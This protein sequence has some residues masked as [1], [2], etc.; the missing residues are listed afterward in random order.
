MSYAE[1]A[2]EYMGVTLRPAQEELLNIVDHA[3]G[4]GSARVAL[5]EAPTGVGK[6]MVPL[7]L[8]HANDDMYFIIV[9]PTTYLQHQYARDMERWFDP[10]DWTV[11]M[12][13][14]NYECPFLREKYPD[15][16]EFTAADCVL[17]NEIGARCPYAY[18]VSQE[19]LYKF[20]VRQ[21]IFSSS[22]AAAVMP[23]Y[24]AYYESLEK[25]CPYYY[26]RLLSA[27]RRIVVTNYDY[28]FLDFFVSETLHFPHVIVF[29]EAHALLDRLQSRFSFKI[30]LNDRAFSEFGVDTMKCFSSVMGGYRDV[31]LGIPCLIRQLE[32][33][34]N[35]EE[36]FREVVS[37]VRKFTYYRRLKSYYINLRIMAR[38]SLAYRGRARFSSGIIRAVL[39]PFLFLGLFLRQYFSA[40]P[41][42]FTYG[43]SE[44]YY[45]SHPS[46]R[47]AILM[48]ATLGG[49]RIWRT[50]LGD[51]PYTY[52]GDIPSPFP[53]ENRTVY[54]PL[55]SR[56][57]R[58]DFTR[59]SKNP[60]PASLERAVYEIVRG[61]LLVSK[62]FK[63][64]A[65]VVHA[66]L[67]S[68]ASDV[69][70]ALLD[71][72]DALG[73]DEDQIYLA[74]SDAI[75]PDEDTTLRDIISRFVS[76]GGI[77]IATTSA[78]EGVDFKGDIARLQYILK[79]PFPADYYSH[80]DVLHFRVAK[81]VVQMAGRVVR[82]KDDFGYTIVLDAAARAHLFR[83]SA[84][85]PK[86]YL[87]AVET[88]F[89]L[90]EVYADI[91]NKFRRRSYA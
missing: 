76:D 69:Y 85:Y 28:F 65:L 67:K 12:G 84:F 54:Y 55:Y 23:R 39:N 41:L 36:V 31:F 1:Y 27:R 5:I 15:T 57:S 19:A 53:V 60:D 25:V 26:A 78:M 86:Y 89:T 18:K 83:H 62:Y 51:V 88:D 48:S 43:G 35:D 81:N 33:V 79:L 74:S 61:F 38:A 29:D 10:E 77:L 47:R 13:R 22:S 58:I 49:E 56:H 73:L 68:L 75:D 82:S 71:M 9:T 80:P 8:A 45:Y 63:R 46:E 3:L 42:V 2:K 40:R 70:D 32:Y 90:D 52:I 66:F 6:S 87:D 44:V 24:V 30:N 37:D 72:K 11:M 16:R 17:V 91:E 64:R 21:E 59:Y 7:V 50:A 20:D 14:R 4:T 34:L